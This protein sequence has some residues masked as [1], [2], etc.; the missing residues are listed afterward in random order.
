MGMESPEASPV[1]TAGAHFPESPR[2]EA[3]S[4]KPDPSSEAPRPGIRASKQM[5]L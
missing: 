3:K 2:R 5:L 4:A 1:S